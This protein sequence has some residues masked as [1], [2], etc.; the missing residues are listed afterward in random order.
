MDALKNPA[1]EICAYPIFDRDGK[2][3]RVIKVVQ[4]IP[5]LEE[6]RVKND[7]S[8]LN[9]DGPADDDPAPFFGMI[10]NNKKMKA[11]YRTIHLVSPSNVTVLIYGESGTG[12]ELV[13]QAVHQNS[14]RRHRPF[15]AIDCGSLSETLLESELFGHVKGAFTG[16]I[17]SK[18]GLFEEAEGGTLFLDE[19]GD[20]SL[21]F[22]AKLLRILQEGEARPVGGNR[23]IKVDVRVIAAT[24]KGLKEAIEKKTFRGDLYYRLAVIPMVIPPLRERRDDIPFL[25]QYFIKKYAD[26]N[27]KG[28]MH[29]S[30]EAIA[31][32]TR[33]PWEGNVRELQNVI[34]RGVLVSPGDE[35]PPESFLIDEA[36]SSAAGAPPTSLVATR[37]EMALQFEKER[38]IEAIRKNKGNKSVAAQSLGISR[39]TLYN[40][41]KQFQIEPKG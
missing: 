14:A 9:G 37:R 11:L 10:G 36:A 35:I 17:Q 12:K 15:V 2:V 40:K 1:S 38:I 7:A 5:A 28:P 21:A 24:N 39:A 23:T 13:A 6:S 25:A 41:L 18:K 22:Q 26:L 33:A 34:E 27:G 19:I 32:L 3:A 20:S 4:E 31:L 16:A 30:R 8:L 29:L